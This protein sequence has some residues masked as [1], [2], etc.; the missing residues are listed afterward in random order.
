[1][2]WKAAAKFLL[3][4]AMAVRDRGMSSMRSGKPSG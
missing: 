1:M 3:I 4:V 2:V